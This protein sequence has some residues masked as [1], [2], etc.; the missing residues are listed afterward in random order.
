MGPRSHRLVPSPAGKN[1]HGLALLMVVFAVAM[2]AAVV[3]EFD[4]TTRIEVVA[5]RNFLHGI[6]AGFLAKAGVE[7]GRGILK[8]DAVHS[9]GYDATNELWGS[10]PPMTAPEGTVRVSI[11]DEGGKLNPNHLVT[12][13]GGTK[14]RAKVD[15]MRRLVEALH[16][17]AALVDALVDWID[18]DRV[19]EPAG[20]EDEFYRA[21]DPPYRAR[22]GRLQSLS[23][24]HMIRG[25]TDQVYDA[26]SPHLTIATP[27][28]GR[29]NI[30]TATLVVLQALHPRMTAE[31]AERVVQARPFRRVDD[32]DKVPGMEQIA[33]ELRGLDQAYDIRS[34]VFVIRSRGEVQDTSRTV[35]ATV[36]RVRAPRRPPEVRILAWR[37]E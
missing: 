25:V 20:A 10:V 2:L 37:V 12:D 8:E 19:A 7:A 23:E 11:D 21:L 5:T 31:L 30:N 17:D 4:R 9:K 29:I 1:E 26:L 14:M 16:V 33:K 32:L 13:N 35:K 36:Q 34:D 3:L 15:Q 27:A 6:Q 24:L 22:N 18:T 28:P